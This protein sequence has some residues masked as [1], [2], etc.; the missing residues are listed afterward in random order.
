MNNGAGEDFGQ[1]IAGLAQ[2]VFSLTFPLVI[3]TLCAVSFVVAILFHAPDFS[4]WGFL[5]AVAIK[6]ASTNIWAAVALA[7]LVLAALPLAWV[8]LREHQARLSSAIG[9]WVAAIA[10]GGGTIWLSTVWPYDGSGW[11]VLTFALLELLAWAALMDA[12]LS[13]LKIILYR[14][15]NRPLPPPGRQ[16]PH[17]RGGGPETI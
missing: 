5:A 3:V 12:G 11:Q 13:T 14:R 17:G 15:A 8:A 6:Y 9:A 1:A 7:V 2:L 16:R 4:F 10:F